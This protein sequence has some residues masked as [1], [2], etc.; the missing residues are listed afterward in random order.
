MVSVAYYRAEAQRCRALA[1]GT[2]DPVAAVRWLRIAKDYESL[3]DSLET[4]PES[5]RLPVMHAPMQQQP[6]QQQQS[7]KEPDDKT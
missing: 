3:A 2:H 4:A 1:A 6:V 5:V 7:K